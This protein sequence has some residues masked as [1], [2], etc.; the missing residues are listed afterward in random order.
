[1]GL[2][3]Q[4]RSFGVIA[5]A[6]LMLAAVFGFVLGSM[7]G[8]VA[9]IPGAPELE[10]TPTA[11]DTPRPR[12][13]TGR[14]D[15]VVRG[16]PPD[17][18]RPPAQHDKT[19]VKQPDPPPVVGPRKLADGRTD[20]I[21]KGPE[22]QAASAE[23]EVTLK[24]ENGRMMPFAQVALDVSSGPLG[25]QTFSTAPEQVRDRRGVFTFKGLHPGEYRV[26]ST[27]A[28]YV[29]VERPVTI[30]NGSTTEQIE[31]VLASLAICVVEFMPRFTDGGT[32]EDVMVQFNRDAGVD[33]SKGRFGTQH[34]TIVNDPRGR[35]A[36]TTTRIRVGQDG[37]VKMS[38]NQGVPVALTF[39]ATREGAA[40]SGNV[41]I[42]PEG[43]AMRVAVTL[44]TPASVDNPLH[45]GGGSVNITL[46][47]S[48]NGSSEHAIT[49]VSLRA[50]PDDFAYRQPNSTSGNRF[51][52]DNIARGKWYVVAEARDVH[53]AYVEQIEVTDGGEHR[54]DI[55]TGRLRVN[56]AREAGSP[57]PAG[58]LMYTV[59]LRPLGSGTIE[60]TYNGNLK[61]KQS[62]FID[63]IV[64]KG[65]YEVLV[66]SPEQS[67]P[68]VAEPPSRPLTMAQ[69]GNISLD[70]VL[71]ASC[72]LIF[73]CVTSSGVP[74]PN[75]EYLVTFHPAGSVP[76]AEKSRLLKAGSDGACRMPNAPY[77]A[78][79]LMVWSS[80]TDWNNPDRVHRLELPAFGTHDLGN[81]VVGQ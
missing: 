58:E 72:T 48:V 26:R 50:R 33:D 43:V 8:G 41:T 17:Q 12:A 80:S 6:A 53:A 38:L 65:E 13:N 70:Y 52:F 19:P 11:R 40:F 69:G 57:D 51:Q 34:N 55:Q 14:D 81:I 67:A 10:R 78:V 9:V 25:W 35:I 46:L 1:M 15:A 28:N 76:E 66:G 7:G 60:R 30:H 36:P 71:R 42:T 23:I 32:P 29:P 63:F 59:R 44:D 5:V 39:T 4:L 64:P 2:R 47:L 75:A 73:R 77:G 27:A 56:A 54:L 62:D 61:G 49:R 79:Y 3:I 45:T 24:D 37:T 74:V 31:L 18:P 16:T 68:L 20:P 21:E 22:L